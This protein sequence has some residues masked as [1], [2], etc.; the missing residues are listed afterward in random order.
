MCVDVA[1]RADAAIAPEHLFPQVAWIRAKTPFVH[2]PVGT[3]REPARRNFEIAPA[4][5]GATVVSLLKACPV[6][7][8]ARHSS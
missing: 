8:A 7:S 6:G 1:Q 4:A 3:K 5:E 2:A